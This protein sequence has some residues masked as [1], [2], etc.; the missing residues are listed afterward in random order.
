MYRNKSFSLPKAYKYHFGRHK[1]RNY[2]KDLLHL[3]HTWEFIALMILCTVSSYLL[4][5][6]FFY[7]MFSMTL[8]GMTLHLALDFGGLITMK[9]LDA[10][11]ISLIGWIK[12]KK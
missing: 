4:K 9:H 11:A 7:Y 5:L 10:R 6:E 1:K 8:L 2:E 12:R 3:F